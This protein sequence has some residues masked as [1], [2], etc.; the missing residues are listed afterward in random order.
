M[1]CVYVYN[2]TIVVLAV[3]DIMANV[4]KC[5]IPGTSAP[6]LYGKFTTDARHK[7]RDAAYRT[8]LPAICYPA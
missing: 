2:N 7:R 4:I 3:L 8:R 6:S 1:W 5:H